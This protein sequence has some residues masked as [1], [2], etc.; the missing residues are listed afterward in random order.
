MNLSIPRLICLC[1]VMT[2]V[3]GVTFVGARQQ[4]QRQLKDR[5]DIPYEMVWSAA[6]YLAKKVRA[7]VLDFATRIR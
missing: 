3:Y 6:G 5:G 1:K 4:I 2:T 7:Y